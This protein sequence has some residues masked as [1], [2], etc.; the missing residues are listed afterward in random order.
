MGGNGYC[1]ESNN[2][3]YCGETDEKPYL[4]L[5]MND[6]K[7]MKKPDVYMFDEPHCTEDQDLL[8]CNDDKEFT[9]KKCED[10]E[11]K[12]CNEEMVLGNAYCDE[13]NN[14]YY[15]GETDEKPYLT[16]FMND[17]KCMK[18]PEDRC[19]DLE[20]KYPD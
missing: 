1:D 10:N 13:S 14:P 3:Y 12:N 18:K 2:S 15:C 6:M 4:T 5:F 8:F 17:M 9:Y 7:C 11:C 19:E 16:L 20:K